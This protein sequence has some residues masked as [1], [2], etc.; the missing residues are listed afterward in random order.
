MGRRAR[1]PGL[2]VRVLGAFASP[3]KTLH[4]NP[5]DHRT[6]RWTG[7]DDGFLARHLRH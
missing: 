3:E 6:I 5:G 1:E 2:R 7:V 4:A